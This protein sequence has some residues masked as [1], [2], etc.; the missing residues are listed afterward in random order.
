LVG[1]D[2]GLIQLTNT[3]VLNDN[4][5]LQ[6]LVP[7]WTIT[8]GKKLFFRARAALNA[9]AF[10][11][12]AL[13]LQVTV[14][15]NNFLTPTDGVFLRKSASNSGMELVNRV[16]GVETITATIGNYSGGQ[17]DVAFYYDGKGT[18]KAGIGSGS[19]SVS[20]TPAA[21]TALPLGITIGVQNTSAAVRIL[22]VDQIFCAKER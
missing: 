6:Q 4:N 3:A 16:G 12:V 17:V 15:A 9:T 19:P 21:I 10:G 7:A 22:T 18:F 2:G 13:G 14:A 8:P 11:S 5:W 20:L 1:G